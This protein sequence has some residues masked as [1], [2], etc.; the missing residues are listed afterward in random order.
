MKLNKEALDEIIL[1]LEDEVIP[2]ILFIAVLLLTL[3][4]IGCLPE[5]AE[6]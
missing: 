3:R 1:L 6:F 2:W 4:L 5:W